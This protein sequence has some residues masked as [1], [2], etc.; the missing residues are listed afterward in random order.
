LYYRQRSRVQACFVGKYQLKI[1]SFSFLISCYLYMWWD[2]SASM[3]V[4]VR[5]ITQGTAF[6]IMR[7]FSSLPNCR[8]SCELNIIITQD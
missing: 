8:S 7:V 3:T 6:C 1:F 4:V 5:N 2:W